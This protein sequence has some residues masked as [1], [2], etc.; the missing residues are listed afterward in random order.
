MTP[1][2]QHRGRASPP[3]KSSPTRWERLSSSSRSCRLHYRVST[4]ARTHTEPLLQ[5][6]RRASKPARSSDS[7]SYIT[8]A[9]A[10]AR[11]RARASASASAPAVVTAQ[12]TSTS[13]S[14]YRTSREG[15]GRKPPQAQESHFSAASESQG[16]VQRSNP[17]HPVV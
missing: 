3:R 8:R 17:R 7:S 2:C 13:E 4:H 14:E 10:S 9:S 16:D 15:R 11:A 1:S 6:S 12:A 5:S